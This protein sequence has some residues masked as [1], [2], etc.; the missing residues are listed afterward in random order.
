MLFAYCRIKVHMLVN[1]MYE[2]Y[3][4]TCNLKAHMDGVMSENMNFLMVFCKL[5]DSH[6]TSIPAIFSASMQHQLIFGTV[7]ASIIALHAGKCVSK[8]D[9]NS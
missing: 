6:A 8:L 9:E 2:Y 7:D 5:L 3:Y 1:K 4:M